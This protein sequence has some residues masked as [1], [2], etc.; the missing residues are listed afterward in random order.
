LRV[1][2][3]QLWVRV[4]IEHWGTMPMTREVEAIHHK[5]GVPEEHGLPHHAKP[6]Q[7]AGVVVDDVP[8]Q[9]A[10]GT[11]FYPV[12]PYKPMITTNISF[13]SLR[14]CQLACL[15]KF[16]FMGVVSMLHNYVRS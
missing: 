13:D 3:L 14:A 4:G 15:H 10:A 1:D 11:L 5:C 12:F 6:R 9:Q 2:V 8:A 16:P 7:I